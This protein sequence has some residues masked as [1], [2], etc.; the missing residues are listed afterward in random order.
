ME[1]E[2]AGVAGVETPPNSYIHIVLEKVLRLAVE[3]LDFYQSCIFII[4]NT[5]KMLPF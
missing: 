2:K 5:L 4:E 1:I 3:T